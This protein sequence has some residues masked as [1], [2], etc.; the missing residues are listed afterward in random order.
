MGSR[1]VMVSN[2]FKMIVTDLDGTYL[3]DDKT[4]SIYSK[5]IINY[6][7]TQG[8]IFVV[9]TARPVRSVISIH[10]LE[11][12]AGIFHN[13]AV[14]YNQKKYIDGYSIKN[15][16]GIV[17]KILGEYKH[18][19]LA[20]ESHDI[21][22]SNFNAQKIWPEVQYIYTSEFNEIKHLQADK[23]II[24]T[25]SI[26]KMKIYEKFL[27]SELYIQLSENKIAM[28]MNRSATKINGILR[29]ANIY[30][31]SLNEIVS[32]GDDYNDIEMIR[33]TGKGIAVSN[34]LPEVKNVADE[35]CESNSSNG[36]ANWIVHHLI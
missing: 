17:N 9:A 4:V 7:R 10:N 22:Y 23:I 31:I 5:K 15:P 26:E 35:I 20:V 6:L 14:L 36:V 21:L 19:H 3:H 12:D 30:N 29:L 32:F 25:D 11:F 34:A 24:E 1:I 27:P 16:Y 33:E 18:C 13:G 8:Y 2:K 28:V